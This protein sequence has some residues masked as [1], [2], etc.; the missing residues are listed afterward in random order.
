MKNI[1]SIALMTVFTIAIFASCKKASV[2]DDTGS[3]VNP[4]VN[5]DTLRMKEAVIWVDARANVFGSYGRFNDTTKIKTTLDTMKSVGI[6]G[7]VIDVKGSSGYTMYNS[8]YAKNALQEEAKTVPTGVDYVAFMIKEAKKRNLK[9]FCSMVTFVEGERGRS[10][11]KVFED[12]VFRDQYQ[13]IVC[14]ISGNRVP[15]T[16]TGRNGFVNPAIPAV[17]ERAL[18]IIKE[19]VAKYNPDGFLMD[20]A[21]YADAYADFSDFSKNDFIKFLEEKYKDT[22][23]KNMNFPSDIVSSW[24]QSG[25][26][27]VPNTTGKYF[28]RWLIYRS[29]IIHDFFAKARVAVKSTN[30]N[31]KFGTYVGAWYATYYQV[32]VNWASNQYDPFND[33]ELRFDWAYPDYEKTGYAEQLDLL[34]T[35]NYFTQLYIND[36]PATAGLK[37]HWWSVE[38]SL[39]GAKYVTKNKMPLYG[40]LDM[41]NLKWS[42]EQAITNT[43]KYLRN[44]ATAGVMLFDVIH[45][46]AP[47]TNYLKKPLWNA[48]KEGLKD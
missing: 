23:A 2:K 34:M 37:Y 47:Q 21:R 39:K 22:E 4:P 26:A 29:T 8:Q 44:N 48:I 17:Q 13:S 1:R 3:V 36:N 15:I 30:P 24:K 16:S 11:G 9:V 32:G 38:G 20:Y 35:G 43:I 25:D 33:R 6:T 10:I 27:I 7:L 18:N 45:V 31:V 40:S 28:K 41:G 46:Y 42:D 14:D 12:A 5:T 19:I